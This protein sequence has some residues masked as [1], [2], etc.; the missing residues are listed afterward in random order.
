MAS[1]QKRILAYPLRNRLSFLSL[2][3]NGTYYARGL[4]TTEHPWAGTWKENGEGMRCPPTSYEL[5]QSLMSDTEMVKRLTESQARV[6]LGRHGSWVVHLMK[7][8]TPD[9]RDRY[10]WNVKWNLNNNGL[11]P[12]LENFLRAYNTFS[13]DAEEARRDQQ[14]ELILRVSFYSLTRSI[15]ASGNALG[16][17]RALAIR[18]CNNCSWLHRLTHFQN[19]ALDNSSNNWAALVERDSN[20]FQLYYN[21]HSSNVFAE[22]ETQWNE[23][24]PAYENPQIQRWRWVDMNENHFVQGLHDAEQVPT[25]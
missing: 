12:G 16:R 15:P 21:S 14:P 7:V 13:K 22:L 24:F 9:S 4:G 17:Q 25:V 23:R 10:Y 3:P 11:Y 6:W 19:L 18:Q 1:T 20:R 8:K 5:P 2:G